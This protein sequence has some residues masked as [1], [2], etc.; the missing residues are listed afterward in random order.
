MTAPHL[1]VVADF[2]VDWHYH[3][4]YGCA[5]LFPIA[6]L[7]RRKIKG[8]ETSIDSILHQ[9]GTGFVLPAFLMLCISYSVP[10]VLKHVSAHELGLAGL[11]ALIMSARELFVDGVNAESRPSTFE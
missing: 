9:A 5:F 4:A 2:L 1:Q 7:T 11:F 6:R 3:A 10:D 8:C